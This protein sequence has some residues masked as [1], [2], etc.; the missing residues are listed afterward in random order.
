MIAHIIGDHG[1]LTD[2]DGAWHD[3]YGI[4][5]DGAVLVRPDGHVGWRSRKAPADPERAL[6]AALDAILGRGPRIAAQTI[7]D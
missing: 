7:A 4:D 5:G 1:E 2:V 6:A 3:A